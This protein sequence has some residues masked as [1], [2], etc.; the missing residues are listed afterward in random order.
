MLDEIVHDLL[1]LAACDPE[2]V[3]GLHVDDMGGIPV[4]VVELEFINAEELCMLFRL[5]QL[6]VQ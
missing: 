2:N 6:P 4:T 5:D 1:F 3:S